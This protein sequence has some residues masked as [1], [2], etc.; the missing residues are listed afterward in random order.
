MIHPPRIKCASQVAALRSGLATIVPLHLLQLFT[1]E[2]LEV[3]VCGRRQIDIELLRTVTE[4][5]GCSA[6]D[7]HVKR[8]WEVLE[9]FDHLERAMFLKFTW[10]RSRLPLKAEDFPQKF[11]IMNF[12]INT[13]SP[14]S[15]YPVSHTCFFQ[16]ELPQ[17]SSRAIAEEKFRYA[18]FNCTAIDGDD[19]E[20][21]RRNAAMGFEDL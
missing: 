11:K 9:S 21:G 8:F 13:S 7:E 16:L 1:G 14:D 19:D 2:D 17:Y 4:Y 6:S 5:S 18:I 10:G 20:T 15:Y 3:M 12:K